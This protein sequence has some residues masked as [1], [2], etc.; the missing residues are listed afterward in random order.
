MK[1]KCLFLIA[2]LLT[3]A[4]VGFAQSKTNSIYGIRKV[5]FKNFNY[6]ADCSKTVPLGVDNLVL[7]N[8]H[9]GDDQAYAD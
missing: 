2:L 5:D 1:F 6:G 4:S 9:K 8:G 7:K 3:V